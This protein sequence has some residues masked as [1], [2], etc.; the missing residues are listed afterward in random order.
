MEADKQIWLDKLVMVNRRKKDIIDKRNNK[1]NSGLLTRRNVSVG[2][3]VF[4][5]NHPKSDAD[6]GYI[7]MLFHLNLGP[8]LRVKKP[9]E[10][11]AV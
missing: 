1:I 2:D 4:V 7:K 10:K 5:R 3:L 11:V 8:Y 9:S 6:T